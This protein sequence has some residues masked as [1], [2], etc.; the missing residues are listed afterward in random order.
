VNILTCNI[1]YFGAQDGANAWPLRKELCAEVIR[2]RSPHVI[3]F[4]EMWGEQFDD[5]ATALPE[6]A[7]FAMADEPTGRRPMNAIFYRRDAFRRISAGGYWLSETPHV[8]GSSSWDSACVRLAN[9]VR[10]EDRATGAEFRVVNTHLDHVSQL[11]RE[12][13]ARLIV[14][15]AAAYGDSYP[16]LL[17][18]D[19]NADYTNPAIAVIRRGGWNDTYAAIHRTEDPGYT[20]HAFQGPE[21]VSRIG[22]MDWIFARGAIAVTAAE[23]ISNGRDGRFPS[24]HYFV[25]ATIAI[26]RPMMGSAPFAKDERQG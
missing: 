4:Q 19:M 12:N 6:F 15:D 13:Q 10:L 16:Q 2:S 18:G 24:D 7:T 5:L 17:T 23:V 1:R 9:W 11:A 3:C 22:K 14:E 20:Y 21:F 25:A 26:G 8:P